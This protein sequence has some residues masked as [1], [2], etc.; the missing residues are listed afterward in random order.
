MLVLS[1]PEIYKTVL[2]F[3]VPAIS[4]AITDTLKSYLTTLVKLGMPL[5]FGVG[6]LNRDG[7]LFYKADTNKSDKIRAV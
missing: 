3:T 4:I 5:H 1:K 2:L 7:V 6:F